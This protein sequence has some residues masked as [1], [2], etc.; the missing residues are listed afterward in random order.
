MRQDTT[1]LRYQPAPPRFPLPRGR[2]LQ[3]DKITDLAIAYKAEQVE[4]NI[5]SVTTSNGALSSGAS[6]NGP[7]YEVRL[8]V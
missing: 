4:N 5:G 3:A 1:K 8:R 7:G 6:G 2:R